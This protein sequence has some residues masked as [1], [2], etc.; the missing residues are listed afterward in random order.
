MHE[1]SNIKTYWERL[2]NRKS[3]HEGILNFSD[4]SSILLE[5]FPNNFNPHLSKLK[6][7]IE[8]KIFAK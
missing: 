5:A 2:K 1:F 8:E 7:L 4:H 3:Y 6:E